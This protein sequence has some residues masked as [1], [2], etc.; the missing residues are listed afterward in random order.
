MPKAKDI[1]SREN[2]I[3]SSFILF[4]KKGYKEVTIINIMEATKLSKGAIYHYFKSKEEIYFAT[5]ETYYFNLMSTAGNEESSGN[6]REDIKRL[7]EFAVE[8]FDQVENITEEGLDYPIRSFFSY[9]LESE[10]IDV[11]RENIHNTVLNYRGTVEKIVS[12]GIKNGQVRKDLEPKIIALRII[13]ILEGLAIHHSTVK[14][15]VK[16]ELGPKYKAIF[17]DFLNTTCIQ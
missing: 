12:N 3:K 6:F 16:K 10:K 5:L 14:R 8:L 9:Q 15:N 7:F 11:V 4:L 17:K 13:S 1:N 2:I